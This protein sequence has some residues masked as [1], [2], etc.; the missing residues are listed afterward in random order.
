[1][2]INGTKSYSKRDKDFEQIHWIN[3]GPTVNDNFW[4]ELVALAGGEKGR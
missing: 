4:R 2:K 1:M 3:T